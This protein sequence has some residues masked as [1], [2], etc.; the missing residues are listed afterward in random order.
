MR[1]IRRNN[2]P[3]TGEFAKYENAKPELVSRLGLFC[4][5]CERK[6]ST[7]LAIEHIEPKDKV[8]TLERVWSNFL[9]ACVNCNSCKSNKNVDFKR[10]LFPDRDNTFHSYTYLDDGTITVSP[11]LSAQQ[12]K[13]AQD[14]LKLVGLDKPMQKYSNSNDEVVA[15]DRSAQRMEAIAIAQQ[16]LS[17]LETSPEVEALKQSIVISAKEAGFFSIW[18]QV[19]NAHPQMKILFI[20]AFKGTEDSGC[21]NMQTRDSITPA[22]NPDELSDGGK[23]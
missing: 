14:T 12:R 8:P 11:M 9:L 15:L 4:S 7:S 16:S 20:K 13:Q 2:S 17:L 6:I 18:M 10:L 22:P 23:V 21:F 5:Y 1:P 19:F 3:I